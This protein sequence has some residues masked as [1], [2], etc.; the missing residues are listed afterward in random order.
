MSAFF[1]TLQDR[2][3]KEL[4][5]E[6]ID[7]IDDANAF[8]EEYLSLHNRRFSFPSLSGLDMHRK[9]DRNIKS[10]LCIKDRRTLRNDNTISYHGAL[11]QIFDRTLAKKVDIEKHLDGSIYIKYN[12]K[13]LRYCKIEARPKPKEVKD[14]PKER[15]YVKPKPYHPWRGKMKGRG[16]LVTK[17]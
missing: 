7:N 3:I 6:G 8:L 10:A 17:I 13:N 15:I 16:V 11:Y 12:G 5:L 1:T 9:P 4:R 2:L 14:K